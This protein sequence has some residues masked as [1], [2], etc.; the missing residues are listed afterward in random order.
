MVR[1]EVVVGYVRSDSEEHEWGGGG[2]WV[3][4]R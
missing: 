1:G 3:C 4:N 2:G